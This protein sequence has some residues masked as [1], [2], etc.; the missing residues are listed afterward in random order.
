MKVGVQ[1]GEGQPLTWDRWR[2]I[3]AM[4]ERLGFHSLFRS[5]HYWNGVQKDAIDVFLSH[6]AT[7]ME[8]ERIRFGT[9]VTPVTFREPVNVGRAAQQLDA[10]SNGRFVLGLG[11]GWYELEHQVYGLDYPPLG[12]RYDR[13][14]EAI[15]LMK[16][17]WYSTDGHY[18]GKYYRLAGT[19][20]QP[21]PPAGRPPILIGGTGRK[22]T[23]GL[24]AA[25]ADEWN[26]VALDVNAYREAA[27]ALDQHCEAIGRDPSTIRRSVLIFTDLAP[28]EATGRL[29]LE[30]LVQMTQPG[31]TVEEA[32]AS[33]RG[34][35]RGSLEQ[36]VDHLGQLAELGVE[37]VLFDHVS[38]DMDDIPEFWAAEVM[39]RIADL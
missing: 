4:T 36:M 33:G 31:K 20:S 28:D 22:R 2:H 8:S 37:E 17:L 18:D 29:A 30:R 35:W 38:H 12:E 27:A 21:H 9:L 34:P 14:I 11:V 23:L 15:E 6:V 7:G 19:D 24:T 32:L 3:V 10:L 39:P 5:D 13:L 26:A 1:V 16:V 25:Y